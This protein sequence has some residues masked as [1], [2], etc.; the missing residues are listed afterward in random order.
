[1]IDKNIIFYVGV[2]L[3][4]LSMYKSF[5]IYWDGVWS[6]ILKL[7]TTETLLYF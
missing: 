2:V 7:Y 4:V 3:L 6:H 5:T 1:M